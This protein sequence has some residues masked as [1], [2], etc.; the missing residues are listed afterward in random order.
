MNNHCQ[1]LENQKEIL[2][3]CERI[4]LKTKSNNFCYSITLFLYQRDDWIRFPLKLYQIYRL[5]LGNYTFQR[6]IHRF[7]RV[8]MS[9]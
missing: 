2:N 8:L 3:K 1:E 9:F 4:F 5:D 7:H 6:R